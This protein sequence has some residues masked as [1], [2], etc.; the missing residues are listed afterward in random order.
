M[1]WVLV[2]PFY[3]IR[4]GDSDSST[5]LFQGTQVLSGRAR[6][7][8]LQTSSNKQNNNSINSKFVSVSA[9]WHTLYT[10]LFKMLSNV[11]IFFR[12]LCDSHYGSHVIGK[13]NWG[14]EKLSNFNSLSNHLL[15]SYRIPGMGNIRTREDRQESWPVDFTKNHT[16][17]KQSWK[18]VTLETKENTNL[19]LNVVIT[20]HFVLEKK[21]QINHL[22]TFSH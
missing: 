6:S 18:V 14:S 19:K 1:K 17:T 5:S 9:M 21:G 10:N 15:G 12:T 20:W 8:V 3:S 7:D 11:F 4:N 16:S 2:S 22:K 13:E